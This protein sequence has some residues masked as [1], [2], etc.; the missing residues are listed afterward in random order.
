MPLSDRSAVTA[1]LLSLVVPPN[2]RA[3]EVHWGYG[4]EHGPSQW[5][6]LKPEFETCGAGKRQSPIDIAVA[7]KADL[8]AIDFKY[9]VSPLHIINNGHT[10]Q[11]NLSSGSTITI[12]DH[13]YALAQFHFHTP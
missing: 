7:E 11:V 5:S 12:A 1:L 3:E 10:I 13:S 2:V 9:Q 6:E 8:P 4:K